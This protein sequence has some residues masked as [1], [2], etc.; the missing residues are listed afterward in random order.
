VVN[1]NFRPIN[2]LAMKTGCYDFCSLKWVRCRMLDNPTSSYITV[3]LCLYWYEGEFYLDGALSAA[4]NPSLI[5][6]SV[7]GSA[8]QTKSK[9]SIGLTNVPSSSIFIFCHRWGSG[10][11]GAKVMS[12]AMA[13]SI[14]SGI[15]SRSDFMAIG[16]SVQCKLAN[17]YILICL[18]IYA[19]IERLIC[20]K[21]FSAKRSY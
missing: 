17:N 1:A 18:V 20:N 16:L 19:L 15:L 12:K 21:L 3:G 2:I 6:S 13:A 7:T 14:P 4:I 10:T 9:I 8:C 11:N 5:T